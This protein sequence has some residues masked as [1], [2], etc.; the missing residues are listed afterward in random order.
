VLKLI[1]QAPHE[2]TLDLDWANAKTDPRHAAAN[3]K[4][5][6]RTRDKDSRGRGRPASE[7]SVVSMERFEAAEGSDESVAAGAPETLPERPERQARPE[8][9]P[10]RERAPRAER[11][12]R[13]ERPARAD[14]PESVQPPVQA[15][16]AERPERD[17]PERERNDRPER[18]ERRPDRRTAATER[19]HDR[20]RRPQRDDGDQPVVGFGS[21]MPAFLRTVFAAPKAE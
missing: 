10:R 16:R 17:R 15:E 6:E 12:E 2:V 7:T 3:K 4:T 19:S 21:D 1:G 18:G 9:Q 20:D 13:T 14:Q 11:P 8:R 5:R